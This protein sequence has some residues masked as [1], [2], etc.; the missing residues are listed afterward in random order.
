M[1]S[2]DLEFGGLGGGRFRFILNKVSAGISDKISSLLND[3]EGTNRFNTF[4]LCVSEHGD[5]SLGHAEE[6]H[7]RLSMWRAY[8]G[9]TNVALVL[10]PAPF[11]ANTNAVAAYTVPVLYRSQ[12]E[13][14]AEFAKY[15]S[16][17][18]TKVE[19]LRRYDLSEVS[20]MFVRYVLFTIL[21]LKHRG[22]EE[23]KE[24][25]VIAAP[26]Y[27]GAR[28]L[29]KTVQTIGGLPQIVYTMPLA[30]APKE[31][32][33]GMTISELIEKIII[34]PT[35]NPIPLRYALAHELELAG[36][37]NPYDR[38]VMSGIPLRR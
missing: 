37:S 7:G 12:L 9:S 32:L 19:D 11:Q 6:D 33:V 16:L 36:V 3:H 28:G 13:F 14:E 38:I 34:G 22:F 18:E 23:E 8:R 30:N 35:A 26:A 2:G 31:N 29:T 1:F 27:F 4:I 17:L 25:R 24:W 10:N 21:S 20:D 15:L 5:G